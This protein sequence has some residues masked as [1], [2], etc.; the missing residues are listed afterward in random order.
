MG[1]T[2]RST[3]NGSDSAALRM[4]AQVPQ[5]D[6]NK[7]GVLLFGV[8]VSG[9]IVTISHPA[10]AVLGLVILAGTS[11]GIARGDLLHPYAWY[12]PLFVLYSASV[13]TLV[14]VGNMEHSEAL[15][16]VTLLQ[17]TALSTLLLV[18]GPPKRTRSIARPRPPAVRLLQPPATALLIISA[19]ASVPY[20]MTI[21]QGEFASK[22]EILL[23]DSIWL[24]LTPAFSLLSLSYAVLLAI[25]FLAGRSNALL[26]TATVG[27]TGF[28]FLVSGE[29]DVLMRVAWISV[30]LY[31]ALVRPLTSR[32]ILLIG[33]GAIV[34]LPVLGDLKNA[35][36]TPD[37]ISVSF[38]DPIAKVLS[39]EFVTA[40]RN[41]QV[42]VENSHAWSFFEGRT[43]LWDI[44][45][46][47][48]PNAV[49]PEAGLTP[50]DW[51]NTLFYDDLV[52]RGGGV[53]FTLVG[54]G[55][56]NFGWLGVV[57]W[58]AITGGFLRVLYQRSA[59]DVLWLAIYVVAMPL[60][61][62][63]VR[64]D[65]A[66][67]LSQFGKHI[68]LPAVALRAT[69]AMMRTVVPVRVAAWTEPFRG[70]ASSR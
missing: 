68:L 35:L 4:Q 2:R 32:T 11:F 56:M 5:G 41:L 67:L 61:I 26:I 19:V 12:A 15:Q 30:F 18:V 64:A 13:P 29:R 66:A 20:V 17:W 38:D 42:L 62:Y 69:A 52:S 33:L 45:R 40:G 28:A 70:A 43:I 34:V 49:F 37:P 36:I 53:G 1:L 59:R 60:A 51:F 57:V 31:H 63:A 27:W 7:W 47:I 54:E 65:L 25:G 55:Y 44:Q 39:D 58:F 50:T 21:L 48:I 23:S 9:A 10:A 14:W 16:H 46:A 3:L 6:L 24:R 8:A 22:F